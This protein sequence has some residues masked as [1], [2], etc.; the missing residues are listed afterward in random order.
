MDVQ[1]KTGDSNNCTSLSIW[2]SIFT[3]I[4]MSA[5]LSFLS[6]RGNDTR[7]MVGHTIFEAGYTPVRTLELKDIGKSWQ[8]RY[9][10]RSG[11]APRTV[12]GRPFFWSAICLNLGSRNKD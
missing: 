10:T 3:V 1:V 2:M 4:S 5:L 8:L 6:V 12:F 11:K 9:D 7:G